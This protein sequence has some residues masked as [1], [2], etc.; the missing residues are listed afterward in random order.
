MLFNE[1]TMM[2]LIYKNHKFSFPKSGSQSYLK[3]GKTSA[4]ISG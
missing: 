2:K 3:Y 1:N 4:T